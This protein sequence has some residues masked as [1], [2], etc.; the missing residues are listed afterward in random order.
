MINKIDLDWIRKCIQDWGARGRKFKSCRPDQHAGYLRQIAAII[1]RVCYGKTH[2]A[3]RRVGPFLGGQAPLDACV[4]FAALTNRAAPRLAP[5][6]G[7]G[8]ALR[9]A[10]T[11]RTPAGVHLIFNFS[12]V[13]SRHPEARLRRDH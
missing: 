11:R 13:Q 12:H 6:P 7:R 4:L 8:P 9:G 3:A 5:T 1:Y 2:R 10:L